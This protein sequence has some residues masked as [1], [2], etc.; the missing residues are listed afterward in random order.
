MRDP[1]ERRDHF[2]MIPNIVRE[3]KLPIYALGLYIHVVSTAGWKGECFKSARTLAKA[4]RCSVGTITNAKRELLRPHW[5]LRFKPLIAIRLVPRRCGGKP[6]HAI[7]P[8]D[9]WGENARYFASR[10]S[11]VGEQ[12]S[13]GEVA[14]SCEVPANSLSEIQSSPYEIASSRGEIKD[15]SERTTKEETHCLSFSPPSRET[16]SEIA[17]E[18]I[19]SVWKFVTSLFG[20]PRKNTIPKREFRLIRGLLPVAPEEIETIRWWYEQEEPILPDRS[21]QAFM[22][23]RRPR[24]V[25][26]LLRNW[27]SVLDVAR[28]F[29]KTRH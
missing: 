13:T 22:L 19:C 3:L 27:N 8:V 14:S 28:N 26:A 2:T 20:R 29:K 5:L 25:E 11:L 6:Y 23:T 15:K 17:H 4:L 18:E 24:S 1:T 12:R 9:I 16:V 21:T 7:T 10:Q